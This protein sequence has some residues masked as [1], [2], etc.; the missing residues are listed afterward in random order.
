ML[1]SAA[2]TSANLIHTSEM[3]YFRIGIL[4]LWAVECTDAQHLN[5]SPKSGGPGKQWPSRKSCLEHQ[6]VETSRRSLV[7]TKA[8]SQTEPEG[9]AITVAALDAGTT[10][11]EMRSRLPPSALPWAS[12]ETYCFRR[13]PPSLR[14]PS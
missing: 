4:K 14:H 3:D 7:V 5:S 9:N 11:D 8:V 2:P 6:R 10:A 12:N 13:G 1:S